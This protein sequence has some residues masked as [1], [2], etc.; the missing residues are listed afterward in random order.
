MDAMKK[1]LLVIAGPTAS[2]K[3]ALGIALAG[4]LN[5]EIV[6]ADSM[7]VYRGMDIGTAKATP[8]E[9]QQVPHHMLDLVDPGDSYSVSRYAEEAGEVCTRLLE[10]GKLPIVVGGTGLYI[11]ALL[12]GRRFAG[13]DEQDGSCRKELA[14]DY[15]RLGGEAMLARLAAVD[16]DRAEKLAPTDRRRIIRAFEIYRLTGRTQTAHDDESRTRP[17]A[18]QALYAVLRFENRGK[19]YERIEQRVDRMCRE[20]LFE[21]T[22]RLLESGVS[23]D[24][25]C[26]QAIGYRQAAWA[27]RGEMPR[28][29]AIAL[30]KQATRRYAKRQLTWF[31][32][33]DEAFWLPADCLTTEEQADRIEKVFTEERDAHDAG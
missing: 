22:A 13:T 4:R 26:M 20:G 8:F 19:L 24:S 15:D 3:T 5:G 28:D 11:D 12:A 29:E 30:I 2:G 32:R 31:R 9:R 25:T 1:R 27:L 16:P 6:S 21:E 10:R 23:P 33:H 17:P 7:Q 18:F 14:R